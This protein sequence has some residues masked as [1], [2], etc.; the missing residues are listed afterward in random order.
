[1]ARRSPQTAGKRERERAKL[2]KRERK[3]EKKAAVRPHARGSQPT[4]SPKGPRWGKPGSDPVGAVNAGD[5]DRQCKRRSMPSSP[6]AARTG[7][8]WRAAP[9]RTRPSR[10]RVW[11]LALS[12]GSVERPQTPSHIGRRNGVGAARGTGSLVEPYAREATTASVGYP[13]FHEPIGRT[14]APDPDSRP[15]R[16]API[17][18]RTSSGGSH[19]D[20]RL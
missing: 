14:R 4:R 17:S 6:R 10:G 1:M 3:Q 18:L 7:S 9:M 8:S 5:R 12:N 19:Q 2:E 11:S 16:C 15:G 13:I 20:V